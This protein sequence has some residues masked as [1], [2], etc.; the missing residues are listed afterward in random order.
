MPLGGRHKC[1]G[2]WVLGRERGSLIWDGVSGIRRWTAGAQAGLGAVT[3]GNHFR[4]QKEL[5]FLD[6]SVPVADLSVP[7]PDLSILIPDMGVLDLTVAPSQPNVTPRL[8]LIS[9]LKGSHE[10]LRKP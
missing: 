3:L 2:W 6:L 9:Q 7:V 5:K 4:S 8:Q 1:L 10:T